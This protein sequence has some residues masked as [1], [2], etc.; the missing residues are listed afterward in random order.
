MAAACTAQS[1]SLTGCSCTLL[2]ARLHVAGVTARLPG[3]P[4]DPRCCPRPPV[5]HL[6]Q[7]SVC[8]STCG[9]GVSQGQLV[10][11]QGAPLLVVP[12]EPKVHA[13]LD[14]ARG[15]DCYAGCLECPSSLQLC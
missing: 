7:F 13:H 15:L 4:Q 12:G 3:G 9:T 8:Q 6:G 2:L 5:P 11:A 10:V 1:Q 14:A